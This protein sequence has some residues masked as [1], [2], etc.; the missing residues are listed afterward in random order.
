MNMEGYGAVA[1][2]LGGASQAYDNGTA[3]MMNNPATLALMHEEH[4][5]DLAYGFLGPTVEARH[6][7]LSARSKADAFSMPAFGWMKK[8]GA[9]AL[10]FGVYGQ[11]GMGTEYGG[12]TFMSAGSGLT[13]R[14]ELSVGRVIFPLAYTVSP[15]L[16]LG[17][18]LDF[19]WMGLDLQ[20]AMNGNQM[21][22][23]GS[24]GQG[25][26]AG[27]L[28]SSLGSL[29]PNDVAY[30]NFSNDNRFTGQARG[31]GVGGKL[32]LVYELAPRLKLGA[33]WHS[34]T[35]VSDM[36]SNRA[37][38]RLINTSGT[39]TLPGKIRIH[40]FQWPETLS[41]GLAWQPR[42]DWLLVADWKR[43][44]WA[45]VMKDFRMR[46]EADA[47]GDLE[48]TLNQNWKNQ[49][50]WMLGA[51]W[52]RTPHWTLRAGVNL[53]ANPVPDALMHPLFPAIVRNHATLGVG[54]A[55]DRAQTLDFG[56]AHGFSVEATNAAG[57]TVNHRQTN[58]QLMYG[59]RY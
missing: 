24:L 2:G 57:V 44:Q 12:D 47:G 29:G 41:V 30:F 56:L 40:D 8:R 31:Y 49:N 25:S 20:M 53:A 39:T 28:A 35:A 38:I 19:V 7:G 33:S 42:P 32:G 5:A 11:G 1:T 51:A 21:Q 3:A 46:F 18:T 34:Q 55:I 48:L 9:L 37:E 59:R 54:Y 16:A 45:R 58:W 43:L 15:K 14:S 23:M 10:G 26:V 17:A 6:G 22:A 4:R 50:V 27:A 52:Q 36:T 13:T